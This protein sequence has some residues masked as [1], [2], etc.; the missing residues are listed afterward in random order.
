[1]ASEWAD[2]YGTDC[3]KME[4]LSDKQPE[5]ATLVWDSPAIHEDHQFCDQERMAQ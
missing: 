4:A 2:V 5:L 1:M 3:A